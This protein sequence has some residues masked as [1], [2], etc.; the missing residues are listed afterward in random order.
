VDNKLDTAIYFKEL[1]RLKQSIILLKKYIKKNPTNIEV[2]A[3]LI[4]ALMLNNQIKEAWQYL[5][6][7]EKLEKDNSIITSY[8]A[9][10]L[11]KEKRLEEAFNT[12][13]SAYN[14]DKN[15]GFILLTFA[16][17]L[18]AMGMRD[19]AKYALDLSIKADT[20]LAEAY[21]LRAIY[22]NKDGDRTNAL[23]DAKKALLLKPHLKVLES[24]T[25]ANNRFEAISLIQELLKSIP[26]K[27]N[28]ILLNLLAHYQYLV[29]DR[30]SAMDTLNQILSRVP[31]SVDIRVKIANIFTEKGEYDSAI[32][33]YNIAKSYSPNN[34]QIFNN[35]GICYKQQGKTLPAEKYF[36]KALKIKPYDYH[37]SI[38]LA[39]LM[40]DEDKYQEAIRIINEALK[41]NPKELD[42]YMI[43]GLSY[44][45]IYQYDKAMK[46]AQKA[47]DIRP[48][49]SMI[50][51]LVGEVY[52]KQGELKKALDS[53]HTSLNYYLRDLEKAK[54]I[55]PPAISKYMNPQNAKI[56]LK[57]VYKAFKEKNI[58]IFLSSGTLLGIVRDGDILPHD[59]DMDIGVD[60][61]VPR[62]LVEEILIEIGFRMQNLSTKDKEWLVTGADK[63][64]GVTVDFFFYK[65]L[66]DKTVYGFHG[67]PYPILW[68]FPHFEL[69]TIE[70]NGDQWLIPS[71]Y[72]MYCR[73]MY[74]EDWTIP[75]ANYD[76]IISS[77]N[78]VKE[79]EPL[80]ICYGIV[81]LI[82]NIK[83]SNYKKAK[84]YCTQL[85]AIHNQPIIHKLKDKL[86][87][88]L[89]DY[90]KTISP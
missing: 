30:D 28:I 83:R 42:L 31:N 59:K 60:W 49:S 2:Y 90:E 56:V 41:L 20:K 5:N 65:K 76:T 7:A 51:H 40:N 36:K 73:T 39:I 89:D 47:L 26:P 45:G 11:L 4:H 81:R 85:L 72:E 1:G 32:K 64:M 61:D 69:S 19:K 3:H 57:K 27:K 21:A 14:R 35:L 38:N 16:N 78:L 84:G 74:G 17:I 33:H 53:L 43:L 75:N 63:E 22:F 68:E 54:I 29:N 10:L 88:I 25:E 6:R 52:M 70:Y 55:N 46:T 8:R 87:S 71:P 50:H 77:S 18:D 79:S 9:R 86:S 82:D 67:E 66:S 48:N 62:E 34:F 44:I 58:D 12:I 37:L 80:A 23:Q 13:Q 15:S 24:I